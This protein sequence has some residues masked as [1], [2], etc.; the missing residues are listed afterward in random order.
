M[1]A[2]KLPCDD[3]VLEGLLGGGLALCVM[4][5]LV[6]TASPFLNWALGHGFRWIF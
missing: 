6:L 5:A 3:V 1:S 2:P 4:I